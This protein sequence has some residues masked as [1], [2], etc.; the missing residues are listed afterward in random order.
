LH[1]V[2]SS[3]AFQAHDKA[4]PVALVMDVV[5][6]PVVVDLARMPHVL[7]SGSNST[8]LNRAIHGMIV[9]LLYQ[10]TPDQA[11]LLLLDSA[12]KVL[13][14]YANLPHLLSTV[15]HAPEEIRDALQWCNEALEKR[16]RMMSEIGVRNI[17][18][19][20]RK[21]LEGEDTDEGLPVK[22]PAMPY[23]VVV[24]HDLAEAFADD[25]QGQA[26]EDQLTRL[27]Q[28]ARAAGIHLVIACH[29]PSVHV[30]TGVLKKNFPTRMVFQVATRNESHTALGQAGAEML[31]G[32]GDMFYLTPGTSS[33]ARLHGAQISS[34]EVK[35]IVEFLRKQQRPKYVTI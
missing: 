26:I 29:E 8:D 4:L 35:H 14:Q 15:R 9:S 24:I 11:K 19:Y 13:R 31:L 33:V 20:N 1:E 23:I 16:Y 2:L 32:N 34:A 10:T 21:V 30:L 27:A 25:E 3:P 22:A 18:G 28:K 17:E 12:H 7:M 5:G 6:H